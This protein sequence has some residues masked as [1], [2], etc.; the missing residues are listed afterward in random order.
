MIQTVSEIMRTELWTVE[1]QAALQE[2]QALMEAHAVRR[3]PVLDAE[4]KLVGIVSW[5]DVREAS[6]LEAAQIASPY[7]PDAQEAWLTVAEVMTENPIVVTPAHSLADAVELMLTHKIG[8]LPVVRRLS[9]S[10]RQQL[11]GLITDSDIFR[12]ALHTWRAE[13]AV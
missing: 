12:A 2:A 7:A 10:G 3:L 9:G 11:V 13:E 8:A 6:T 1:T 5:G 4:N